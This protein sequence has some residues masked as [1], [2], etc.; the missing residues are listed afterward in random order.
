[1]NW[2]ARCARRCLAGLVCRLLRLAAWC[3]LVGPGA[4]VVFFNRGEVLRWFA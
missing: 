1:M 3:V 4:F 2:I